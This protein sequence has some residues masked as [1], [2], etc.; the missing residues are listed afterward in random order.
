MATGWGRKS[1]GEDNWGDLSDTLVSVS[2]IS[3]SITNRS[4]N[5]VSFTAQADAQ[6]SSDQSKFGGTSLELDGSGDRIQSTDI[7]LG[8]DSYTWET[9]AYFNSFASKQCILVQVKIQLYLS[10]QQIYK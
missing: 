5:G 1:W 8:T 9:F 10:H 7:T 6:L 2:G 3:L 4:T